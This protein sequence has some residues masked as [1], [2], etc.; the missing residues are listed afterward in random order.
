MLGVQLLRGAVAK[1]WG[2]PGGVPKRYRE[3]D[4]RGSRFGAQ[5]VHARFDSLL[6]RVEVHR[7]QL[8]KVR[9]GLFTWL[10]G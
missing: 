7:R 6:P 1:G 9:L 2:W 8:G 3:L 10:S 4:G 5:V